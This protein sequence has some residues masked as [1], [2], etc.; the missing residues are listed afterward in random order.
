MGTCEPLE[1]FLSSLQLTFSVSSGNTIDKLH[2][3]KQLQSRLYLKLKRGLLPNIKCQL[4]TSSFHTILRSEKS[5]RVNS[6]RLEGFPSLRAHPFNFGSTNFNVSEQRINDETQYSK[7]AQY[8]KSEM[9]IF[10]GE[11]TGRF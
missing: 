10:Q 1:E 3:S 2:I 9:K 5:Y 8:N 11:K 7:S 4:L 6:K